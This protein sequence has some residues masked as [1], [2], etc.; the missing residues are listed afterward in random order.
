MFSLWADNEEVTPE[1]RCLSM[2]E[3]SSDRRCDLA[4]LFRDRFRHRVLFRD[5]PDRYTDWAHKD[6]GSSVFLAGERGVAPTPHAKAE[7]VLSLHILL[8]AY[9]FGST[10]ATAVVNVTE[11]SSLENAKAQPIVIEHSDIGHL[12]R[13]D[14]VAA[15]EQE[16]ADDQ[17]AMS[18]QDI[19]G[20]GNFDLTVIFTNV[21][22]TDT[23]FSGPATVVFQCDHTGRPVKGR[24]IYARELIEPGTIEGLVSLL[25]I[26][27]QQLVDE[28]EMLIRD[29][30]LLA[31]TDRKII[32][33]FNSTDGDFPVYTRLENL[34][35][36]AVERTPSEIALRTG[37]LTLTYDQLNRRV[38]RF[39]H[40]LSTSP[41]D[42]ATGSFVGVILDK[43]HLPV[44][45]TLA[46]WKAGATCVP[47]DPAQPIE[48]VA[49][50]LAQ[51]RTSFLIA[52]DRDTA[53][54]RDSFTTR[55]LDVTVIAAE[56]IS[57]M[58]AD[59]SADNLDL[60]L[61]SGQ[62]AYLMYTSGTT[63]KP[64]CVAK[65][66]VSVVNSITDLSERYGMT[67][68]PG[69]EC[70]ALF[71]GCGFEP[72][73]RQLLLALVNSQVLV[74]VPETI[75]L[76]PHRLPDF[77]ARHNVT[78]LNG[79]GS[80]IRQFD[81]TRCPNLKRLALVGEEL[82][83]E[84]LRA[85]RT[86]F[87][88]AV[89]NEYAF[90]E[91]TFVTAL[92]EFGPHETERENR[93]IGRPLRNV[94]WYVLDTHRRQLPVGAIGE[95][96]VGGRGVADGYLN[97]P[98]LSN[99]KF[100][101][102][103]VA[104]P[105]P[106]LRTGNGLIYATG[107]LAR[108][109]PNGE[110]EFLGRRDFQLKINGVRIEPAEI[111]TEAAKFPGISQCIVLPKD[112]PIP[113]GRSSLVGFYTTAEDA[114]VRDS[115]VTA[116]LKARL[117]PVMVPSRMVRLDCL[118][119]TAIGK[120]DW[121][122]L[123]ALAQDR[124]L[125][126][127]SDQQNNTDDFFVQT[128][129]TIWA[130]VLA[131]SFSEIDQTADFFQL[132]GDS[133]TA[134]RL[135]LLIRERL[136][137]E[138][139]VNAVFEHIPFSAFSAYVSNLPPT[140]APR[141]NLAQLDVQG[142][143][144]V[145]EQ[146]ANGL[147]QGL[148]FYALNSNS[149]DDTY[150]MQT[151]H[152][153]R[154]PIR[155]DLM[156]LA[157]R[158]AY[159]RFPALRLRFAVNDH[160]VQRLDA[161][162]APMDWSEMDLGNQ[163]NHGDTT[164]QLRTVCDQL[165]KIPFDIQ[166][167][168][169][170]RLRFIKEARN[171]NALV[172]TCHHILLDGWSLSVL[173]ETVHRTYLGLLEGRLIDVPA[174]D[175]FFAVQDYWSKHSGEHTEYWTKEVARIEQ[176][177]DLR[178][179]LKTDQRGK[180]DLRGYNQIRQHQK[181]RTTID[182]GTYA[183]LKTSCAELGLT[184]H[185][186]LQFAWHSALRAFGGGK[187]TVIGTVVSGRAIPVS[188]IETAVGLFINTLPIIV[189]HG[190][191]RADLTVA[192]AMFDIQS[193]TNTLNAR[194]IVNL[195]EIAS[196]GTKGRIFDALL[197]F[198][199]YKSSSEDQHHQ[200]MLDFERLRD[201]NKVDHPL[202]IVGR[203]ANNVLEIEL[204]YAA[205]IFDASMI[206]AL[207]NTV[208]VLFDQIS[209]N[210]KRTIS[211]LSLVDDDTLSVFDQWNATERSFSKT[212]TLIDVFEGVVEKWPQE[213]ALVFQQTNLTYSEL[214]AR[215][216]C[217]AQTIVSRVTLRPDDFIAILMDKSEWMIVSIL[218]VWKAGAAFVP[219]DPGYPP[220][221]VKFI[222]SDTAARLL[223]VDPAHVDRLHT[224]CQA[225]ENLAAIDIL[226]PQHVGLQS[227]PNRSPF[228][229]T[230]AD[231][232]A[233]G[234]YTSGTT[235]Q[236]KA[237]LVEHRGVVNLRESLASS[238]DLDRSQGQH[239]FLSFS[240]FVFDHFI[241][242]FADALLNGQTLVVLDD[243]LRTD[244][245]ALR[246]YIRSNSVTYLSGTPS[247]LSSYDLFECPSIRF[248]DA[249]GE[250][251][252]PPAFEAI[253]RWF[254]GHIINGYGP[255]E[256]SITS[257][258]RPY[259]FDEMRRDKSIGFP[260]SNTRCYIL[261][262][263]MRR[264]PVGGIGELYIGGVGVT[265]GYLN[266]ADLTAERFVLDPFIIPTAERRPMRLYRTGDLSRWLPNG[267][268]EYFGRADGQ[269]KI[270]GQRVEL[271]EIENALL[272]YPGVE[273]AI[274]VVRGGEGTSG[275]SGLP[276]KRLEAFF[277]ASA[278]ISDKEVAV[279]L[280]DRLPA[281]IVPTQITQ[282]DRVPVTPSGKLDIG[283]LPLCDFSKSTGSIKPNSPIERIL[284]EIWSEVLDL[285]PSDFGTTDNFFALGGDSLRAI[286]LAIKIKD[287]LD[288]PFA[289]PSVFEHV[290]IEAQTRGL[291][292]ARSTDTMSG[293]VLLQAKTMRTQIT[294]AQA[295]LVFVDEMLGGTSAYNIPLVFAVDKQIAGTKAVL[296]ALQE[297]VRRH[298]ALRT[299]IVNDGTGHWFLKVVDPDT[300]INTI[301]PSP[302]TLTKIDELDGRLFAAENHVF[303]L[304]RELPVRV[305]L[306]SLE[307]DSRTLYVG[308][309]FHHTC[310]DGHSL[311][312]FRREFVQLITGQ[313][314]AIPTQNSCTY[315]DF[316]KWQREESQVKDIE[317]SLEFWRE[318][319][320]ETPLL[321]LPLDKS[322]PKIFDP[323]G[324]EFPISLSSKTSRELKALA[325]SNC[326]SLYTVL[327]A[328]S[329]LVIESF[330]GQDD[331]LISTPT[332]NR[333]EQRFSDVIGL[334]S[335]LVVMR[336]HVDRTL[337]LTEFLKSVGASVNEVLLHQHV[338]FDSVVKAMNLEPDYSRHPLSQALVSLVP[339]GVNPNEEFDTVADYR[340]DTKGHTSSKFDL[341]FTL[342]ETE[343][344]LKGNVTV[345]L[346]IFEPESAVAYARTFETVADAFAELLST[347][348]KITIDSIRRTQNQFAPRA[349]ADPTFAYTDHLTVPSL[350]H[351]FE[352]VA[353]Q[354]G[355]S[356]ALISSDCQLTYKDLN[357]QANH[358]ARSL[359]V[360]GAEPG[361]RIAIVMGAGVSPIIAIL[362]VWKIGAAYVPIDPSFPDKRIQFILNDASAS[363]V[364]TNTVNS[365][366]MMTLYDKPIHVFD[367]E[368]AP[369]R[370]SSEFAAPDPMNSSEAYI[371]YTSGTSGLPKGVR[372]TH[373]NVL[374][375]HHG[376]NK[377]LLG[378]HSTKSQTVLLTSNIVFDF[379]IEQICLSILSG[380]TLLVEPDLILDD[381][382]YDRLSENRLSYLS[383]TPTQIERFDL[384]RLPFLETVLL[385]GEAVRP[386]HFEKVRA[387]FSGRLLTAYGT[388]E[389][390]VYNLVR[391]F[392]SEESFVN[393]L[394]T[395][396]S[397]SRLC[398]L[399]NN[400]RPVPEGARGQ[401][402]LSGPCVS[403]G[404]INR[405]ELSA[406]SF[407]QIAPGQSVPVEDRAY[408]TGDIVRRHPCGALEFHGR[409]D[410]QAKV[411]GVRIELG[412]IE[413]VLARH[414]SVKQCAVITR[415]S[416]QKRQ[417]I[418]AYYVPEISSEQID[419]L[420]ASIAEH[421]S[422]FL[423]RSMLP[424]H[425]VSLPSSLPVTVNGKLNVAALPV[426]EH[427][428]ISTRYSAPR[429]TLELELCAAFAEALGMDR[430]GI[431][432]D[433]FRL[434]GDSISALQ[435]ATRLR[436]I[437]G[438]KANVRWVFDHPTVRALVVFADHYSDQ[439]KEYHSATS[440]LTDTSADH[441]FK[442]TP[443]QEWF[444][445]KSLSRHAFWNQ[446]FAIRTEKLDMER[447][448]SALK[449]L[450]VMHD[451]FSLCFERPEVP[452][453]SST[454]DWQMYRS[455]EP[456]ITLHEFDVS[457]AA[458]EF[459][460]ELKDKWQ[461]GFSLSEGNLAVV[462][463][464]HGYDDGSARIWFAAHHLIMD[465]VSWS[466][467]ARDL[468]LLYRGH[469]LDLVGLGYGQWAKLLRTYSPKPEELSHWRQLALEVAQE[470]NPFCNVSHTRSV[471]RRHLTV[472][473][474]QVAR[475]HLLA[476]GQIETRDLF[477][478]AVGHAARDIGWQGRHITV[479]NHGREMLHV[480]WQIEGTVGWFTSLHPMRVDLADCLE[481]TARGVSE[482]R[483]MAPF[484][485]IGYG[486]ICGPLGSEDAPL[487][488]ICFNYLGQL[489]A[490]HA[491]SSRHFGVGQWQ[492][493]N[494]MFGL[495]KSSADHSAN[496]ATLD[497]TFWFDG[498][499][500]CI[501]VDGCL[502]H[503]TTEKFADYLRDLLENLSVAPS[504]PDAKQSDPKKPGEIYLGFDFE[505]MVL[506]EEDLH[507]PDLFIL[508]PG[509]G[510]AESYLGNLSRHLGQAN[511]ILFNNV[512]QHTPMSNFEEI[513]AY[514]LS[515]I[516]QRRPQGP[517]NLLGWSFG[518]V[519]ALQIASCLASE[520]ERVENLI[521][522]DPFWCLNKA[523]GHLKLANV[524][525]TIDPINLIY[526][527][528]PQDFEPLLRRVGSITLFKAKYFHGE[529]GTTDRRRLFEY[530]A[531]TS[532]NH[533]DDLIPENLIATRSLGSCDHF[534]WVDDASLLADMGRHIA[535]LIHSGPRC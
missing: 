149:G 300:A 9:G 256:I 255:T 308:L 216:N 10:T 8:D 14:V 367:L 355:P 323:S 245:D 467:I 313:P 427:Q 487:P 166:R 266:R 249:I 453:P 130:E 466:V 500:L 373:D 11:T 175:A 215:A 532:Y 464:L 463:Y 332:I 34:V 112:W 58:A 27:S 125:V 384:S 534:S 444:F 422:H 456:S 437:I 17:L 275:D 96:Y 150:V 224:L 330:S 102:G 264:I 86:V 409:D 319:L 310:I 84:G 131:V 311:A 80:I 32:E 109:L 270:N 470:L 465:R 43:G 370:Q 69:E 290:T 507:A 488:L 277:L 509:E 475:F 140:Q 113:S 474:D 292:A 425:V 397:N 201:V 498:N 398:I 94:K 430:I 64:K 164:T 202:Q 127:I 433:F 240:N 214:D 261:D 360:A 248:V 481:D 284:H 199:N 95:L 346:A 139:Q 73:M 282:I 273:R 426:P 79:T 174:D 469:Q 407:L 118:P 153:Y 262:D 24:L 257:H 5:G 231:D 378:A 3:R 361:E 169:L 194:S 269:A 402:F 126:D 457:D 205:E 212:A 268:I 479:E 124:A 185:S 45:T 72:F 2:L 160:P 307:G 35:E 450:V 375:Y 114:E 218:A 209:E 471:V 379:S 301:I 74:I 105:S 106:N 491:N 393:D 345:P 382:M 242:Q 236:P 468:E 281:A 485:G 458:P 53:T 133:I 203:E 497:V 142:V 399:D 28:P 187:Q 57:E 158:Q 180:T 192:D 329:S 513:S 33:R 280:S 163:E 21:D 325:R 138:V 362:A 349:E 162:S 302:V 441:A 472:S 342:A 368:M 448:H 424:H 351:L 285:S 502:E 220:S 177:C 521:L 243:A 442:L 110:A 210:P 356:L 20:Q 267:E 161:Q 440:E 286:R 67:A 283:A 387:T 350:A 305:D 434:G 510:G 321:D 294:P 197:M 239:A 296:G 76:D 309:T 54:L 315:V 252:T 40:C 222:L 176:D 320:A 44:I 29:L 403:A 516:R 155:S 517:Y 436:S 258:K 4:I 439:P 443:I 278:V 30:G 254:G 219:I 173:H 486:L 522:I 63:G 347:A 404:Y 477:L 221:R 18:A 454:T 506:V 6:I 445:A 519:V 289:L 327:L 181:R 276:Q 39:A 417:D 91:A 31:E 151:V 265:R 408:A 299:L 419:V 189:E 188:G 369:A 295:R 246:R 23:P 291:R 514:Y 495:R 97:D 49:A 234:I 235:G 512:H 98:A 90:T 75:R 377:R 247:V 274:V 195:A 326:V 121:R 449:Q 357:L 504:D 115:D 461:D 385:A 392:G 213:R 503:S 159:R 316:A 428:R 279:W 227:V 193:A 401:L 383:G 137:R 297:L 251:F 318:H 317:A 50:I 533:L 143:S 117:L 331:F 68:A 116:F 144:D 482:W 104:G 338:P 263:M 190:P 460:R 148:L 141:P 237:V 365:G 293:D 89:F 46:L 136:Q 531:G 451:A 501:E 328:I 132:G 421:L 348:D 183:K 446:E 228:R 515:K 420:S 489:K 314:M 396:L 225:D 170:F 364:L 288:V 15:I 196:T 395:Q 77:L 303:H 306:F 324:F 226:V 70:V 152:R 312:I 535:R 483:K 343:S 233:Y 238:F 119:V 418:V 394:G 120:V 386:H 230:G 36:A 499:V 59:C 496:Q 372:V 122:E 523:V 340:A 146:P 244:S 38:N 287:R 223:L 371:I 55:G 56:S 391:E 51:T 1:E 322:R 411:N 339:P 413:A 423:P 416:R 93:S 147:Q 490:I 13:R 358:L 123:Q 459:L 414:P 415:P 250:D 85:L 271:S 100:H 259:A 26:I 253:R 492:L 452:D 376:L 337:T 410:T 186:A 529:N 82:T 232:L 47:I 352:N 435:L 528:K 298:E 359:V 52:N 473:P 134:I 438:A 380:N 455:S 478:S 200:D 494:D 484:N 7:A 60:V 157:W 260:V 191:S 182:A 390:T 172:F 208:S 66:H 480:E 65:P 526:R 108:M 87:Q 41:F 211:D 83:S 412:E 22:L 81:L 171:R 107:D 353:E 520:G 374:S 334:F 61:R 406:R 405:P 400:R 154:R 447:L 366:R 527:P 476:D 363:R 505:P 184:T 241:E 128:L 335:N 508:P 156:E 168:P 381:E 165:R 207:L 145:F 12:P 341:S 88:G 511:Q 229:S 524:A 388:T 432:D 101:E 16:L 462:A 336:V 530:F 62:F 206:A 344:G 518:G 111:E 333:P 103:I 429:N 78:H 272:S 135:A 204:W 129:R 37:E 71:S 48:R 198:E 42:V 525:A 354:H 99:E 92:K 25:E 431:D 304:E 19:L 389:T 167:G 493:D 178:G 217:L 179:L